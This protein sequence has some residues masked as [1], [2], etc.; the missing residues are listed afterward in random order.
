MTSSL[1]Q[2]ERREMILS[3]LVGLLVFAG[4]FK[5]ERD[6]AECR[7]E[8]ERKQEKSRR[9]QNKEDEAFLCR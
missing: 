8:R 9:W 4:E 3:Q 7:R 5:R 1:M 2:R 6:E